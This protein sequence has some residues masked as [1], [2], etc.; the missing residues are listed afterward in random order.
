[1]E[2]QP[3]F[4]D[5]LALLNAHGVDYV[6]VGA[7]ALAYHGAPRYTGDMDVYVRSDIENARR[8]M[9]ALKDFGFETL[10]LAESDFSAPD[11]TIQLG[12]PPVR[13]DLVTSLTGVSWDEVSA[14][15]VA[16]KYGDVPVHYIGRRE[17]VANKRACGRKK[18]L[19]DLEALGED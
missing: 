13:V 1:M 12:N 18:D 17:F 9:T 4:R 7:H 19:A 2:V 14:H 8:I 15:K 3:D 6:I 16:G 10:G 11:R 5:L